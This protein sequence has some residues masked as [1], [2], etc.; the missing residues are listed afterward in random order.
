MNAGELIFA[1]FASLPIRELTF[2]QIANLSLPFGITETTLRTSLARMHEKG[3]LQIEKRG[4]TAIYSFSGKSRSVSANV[5]AG[6][7][8]AFPPEWNGLFWGIL[9]SLPSSEKVTRHKLRTKLEAYRY[10]PW[11]P[12]IWIRP[13]GDRKRILYPEY[14]RVIEFRPEGGLSVE[15]A[16]R[17]T[18]RKGRSIWSGRPLLWAE[19]WIPWTDYPPKGPSSRGCTGATRRLMPWR[20]TLFCRLIFCPPTGRPKI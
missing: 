6:F 7:R 10:A 1:F 17:L 13:V 14:C 12:G 4:R 5:S 15:E 19:P 18:C 20:E 16:A 2:S 11:M 8:L 3:L 9:F